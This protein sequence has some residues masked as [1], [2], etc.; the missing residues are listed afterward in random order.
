M[1]FLLIINLIFFCKILKI[2]KR[3]N[4]LDFCKKDRL[5]VL[6]FGSCT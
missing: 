4:L 1:I 5:L 3:Y 2:G 6:N